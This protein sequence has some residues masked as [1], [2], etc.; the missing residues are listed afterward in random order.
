MLKVTYAVGFSGNSDSR[1]TVYNIIG[2]GIVL[3]VAGIVWIGA[4]WWLTRR[5]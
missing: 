5:K 4:D 1:P 3:I 2:F